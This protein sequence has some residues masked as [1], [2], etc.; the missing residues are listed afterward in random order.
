MTGRDDITSLISLLRHQPGPRKPPSEMEDRIFALLQSIPHLKPNIS[1]Q[2]CRHYAKYLNGIVT[3]ANVNHQRPET[4]RVGAKRTQAKLEKLSDLAE[5]MTVEM[6]SAHRETNELIQAALPEGS[7]LS[8]YKR[9][10]N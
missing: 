8:Q 5:K 2:Q 3:M 4:Q 7:S 9:V 6:N 10:M 1:E